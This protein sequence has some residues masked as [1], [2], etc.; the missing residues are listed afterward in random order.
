MKSVFISAKNKSHV[1]KGK[2]NISKQWSLIKECALA[3]KKF[4]KHFFF[5]QHSLFYLPIHSTNLCSLTTSLFQSHLRISMVCPPTPQSLQSCLPLLSA[6]AR[7]PTKG[8]CPLFPI[9]S[10]CFLDSNPWSI[11][12]TPYL[13][14]SS[15]PFFKANLNSAPLPTLPSLLAT[16]DHFFTIS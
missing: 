3:K 11:P 1:H 2:I 12:E 16:C 4:R 15:C 8:G 6:Y 13:A 10:A 5:T 9:W 7:M 14:S